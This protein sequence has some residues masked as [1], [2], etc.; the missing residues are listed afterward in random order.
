MVTAHA[1]E[2]WA[3]VESTVNRVGNNYSDQI[4][5]SGHALRITDLERLADL[6]VSR[7]RYPM[8]W[9]RT[10]PDDLNSRSNGR[11]LMSV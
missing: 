5:R 11:G 2:L 6:G 9:E 3:G 10:A 1:P 4:E 8:L 7:L